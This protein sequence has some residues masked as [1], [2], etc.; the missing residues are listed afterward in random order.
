MHSQRGPLQARR[1]AMRAAPTSDEPGPAFGGGWRCGPTTRRLARRWGGTFVALLLLPSCGTARRTG[2]GDDDDEQTPAVADDAWTDPRLMC[3]T[4]LACLSEVDATSFSAAFEVYSQDGTCWEAGPQFYETCGAACWDLLEPLW[5]SNP[6]IDACRVP[7]PRR[8][9]PE[10][11]GSDGVEVGGGGPALRGVDQYADDFELRQLYGADAVV[12]FLARG[13]WEV[14]SWAGSVLGDMRAGH[15][16]EVRWV[17]A[18]WDWET[19]AEPVMEWADETNR[20]D[21]LAGGDLWTVPVL[22]VVDGPPTG[23]WYEAEYDPDWDSWQVTV[24][25]ILVLDSDW[26]ILTKADVDVSSSTSFT[27]TDFEDLVVDAL[28]L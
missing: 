2:A 26:V 19:G 1:I 25:R 17:T 4:Y 15:G 20:D 18:A 24:Y 21:L 5:A 23:P 3:D 28:G 9:W 8:E 11:L 13:E 12:L 6:V 22:A 16:I 14:P 10:G 7:W 27:R